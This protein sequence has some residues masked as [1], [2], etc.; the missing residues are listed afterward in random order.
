MES[1]VSHS[2]LDLIVS[3]KT[4]FIQKLVSFIFNP[5]CLIFCLSEGSN[6]KHFKM[7]KLGL[8]NLKQSLPEETLLKLLMMPYSLSYPTP[9]DVLLWIP[10]YILSD[11][12][13]KVI[14]LFFSIKIF[15]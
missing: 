8:R 6:E 1:P 13:A 7:I 12:L 9:Q 14:G 2:E 10:L 5:S 11:F 4:Y 3:I 15:D